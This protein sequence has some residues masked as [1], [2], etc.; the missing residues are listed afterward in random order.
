MPLAAVGVQE[1]NPR[2]VE[3][4]TFRLREMGHQVGANVVLQVAVVVH[5]A[6][7]HAP[8]E[9]VIAVS[10]VAGPGRFGGLLFQEPA[11]AGDDQQ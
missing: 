4:I 10:V 6:Q 8:D 7:V 2:L 3:V 1:P 11:A 9:A 5:G